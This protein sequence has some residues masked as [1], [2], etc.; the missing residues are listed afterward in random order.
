METTIQPTPL[1]YQTTSDTLE[2]WTPILSKPCTFTQEIFTSVMHEMIL[3]PNYN[4]SWIL[5]A[6]ILSDSPTPPLQLD[7][8]IPRPML[9]PNFTPNRTVLRRFVPRNPQRDAAAEQTCTF[10]EGSQDRQALVVYQSHS[11][12]PEALPY[13]LPTVRALA[14]WYSQ[15]GEDGKSVSIYYRLFPD[16]PLN[17]RLERT[18]LHLLTRIHK[19]GNGFTAGY[20]KRVYHDQIIPREHF[21]TTYL[22]LRERHAKRLIDRWVENTDPGKHVFEDI[23]IAAFLIELWK[24][25][26][27]GLE[28]GF[29]DIGCGNGVLVDILIREGYT[30]W[31]FDARRRKTWGVLG[32]STEQ[33]LHEL[34]LVPRL[35]GGNVDDGIHDGVFPAGTF[36]ISNHADELTPW[37]PLLAMDSECPFLMI[38]CCS[39]DLSGRRH[40]QPGKGSQYACL[41]EWVA[42]LAEDVGWQIEREV[43]RIPSTRNVGIIGRK[44]GEGMTVESVL[45]REGG[46]SGWS[47]RALALKA[48][49]NKG[50]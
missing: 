27:R 2:Q 46:G 4:S 26:D 44:I 18:A 13:Y 50:H 37:T 35:L 32:S 14:F 20:T 29:V 48:G 22:S 19:L 34:V 41:V 17:N 30:G 28:A 15:D 6:D 38:P 36:I 49:G 3:N 40:R 47:E 31:G 11:D 10:Y 45:E 33:N 7:M 25:M 8:S 1:Y 21:Q 23:L 16:V 12:T 24:D 39:H 5:R 43:L 9:I 42:R